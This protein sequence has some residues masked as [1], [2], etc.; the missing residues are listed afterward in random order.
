MYQ[1]KVVSYTIFY[2]G[3]YQMIL[4]ILLAIGNTNARD[5]TEANVQSSGIAVSTMY[6]F[7]SA[8]FL[9]GQDNLISLNTSGSTLS[10]NADAH[11]SNVVANDNASSKGMYFCFQIQIFSYN[12]F[13]FQ[14]NQ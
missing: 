2:S 10:H 11:T 9:I 8:N 4:Y 1:A 6:V 3:T 5:T 13:I 12:N 14:S 7:L